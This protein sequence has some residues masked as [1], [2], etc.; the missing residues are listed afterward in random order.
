MR[1]WIMFALLIAA[2]AATPA[3]IGAGCGGD[4][5]DGQDEDDDD[6]DCQAEAIGGTYQVTQ[7]TVGDTCDPENVG[8][9]L[10]GLII[11][12]Q[13][14]TVP[15]AAVYWQDIGPGGQE[16]LIFFGTICGTNI[17]GTS[18]EEIPQA[19]YDCSLT[20]TYTYSLSVNLTSGELSGNYT[21]DIRWSGEQCDEA[22][23][24]PEDCHWNIE[25]QPRD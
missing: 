6:D 4:D 7:V 24:N 14:G 9:T 12:E 8:A 16:R 18:Y 5:D 22:V 2:L 19:A 17:I 11:I 10:E 1:R 23:V 25:V 15:S 20:K 13:E 3:L 21:A